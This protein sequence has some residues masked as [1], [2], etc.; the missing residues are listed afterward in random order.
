MATS[1]TLTPTNVTIQIP[2][3]SDAPNASVFSNCVDK[4]ADA[5]NTLQSGKDWTLINGVTVETA[6][7]IPTNYNEVYVEGGFSSGQRVC[8]HLIPKGVRQDSG[9]Y[10]TSSINGSGGASFGTDKKLTVYQP[11]FGGASAN[12]SSL[13]V[14]AR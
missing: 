5:V 13:K 1:K 3:M 12:Y 4:L 14:W 2:A 6:F 10:Y 11:Y 7:Q 9:F 8:L